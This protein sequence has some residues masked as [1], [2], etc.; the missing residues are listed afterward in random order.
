MTDDFKLQV[1][2]IKTKKSVCCSLL[3]ESFIFPMSILLEGS[4]FILMYME[5]QCLLGF[6]RGGFYSHYLFDDMF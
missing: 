4:I 2:A 6:A 1:K 3:V 5:E